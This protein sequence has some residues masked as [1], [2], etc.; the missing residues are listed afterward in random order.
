MVNEVS[1]MKKIKIKT[2][3]SLLSNQSQKC[4][5]VPASPF[6]KQVI[7]NILRVLVLH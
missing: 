7:R 2:L 3:F 4:I 5:T 6:I 1:L